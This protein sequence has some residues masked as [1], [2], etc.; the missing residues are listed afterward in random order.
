MSLQ[1]AHKSDT[2]QMTDLIQS[3][4]FKCE[5]ATMRLQLRQHNN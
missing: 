2:R 5:E 1:P 4:S 3:Q